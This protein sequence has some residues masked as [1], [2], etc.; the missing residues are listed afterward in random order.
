MDVKTGL[1]ETTD[2]FR[3]TWCRDQGQGIPRKVVPKTYKGSHS[4]S[5]R[6]IFA[7]RHF[8]ILRGDV[9]VRGQASNGVG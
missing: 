4:T 5:H 2:D 8:I 3:F 1:E 9:V 6:N 7:E